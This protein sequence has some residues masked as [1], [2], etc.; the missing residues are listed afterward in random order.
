MCTSRQVFVDC[1][2][3]DP[4]TC[5]HPMPFQ[6]HSSITW[7][8]LCGAE[9][10]WEKPVSCACYGGLPGAGGCPHIQSLAEESS[11]FS[12]YLVPCEGCLILRLK[13]QESWYTVL[14]LLC[15]YYHWHKWNFLYGQELVCLCRYLLCEVLPMQ[16][17]IILYSPGFRN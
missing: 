9:I 10:W 3:L 1:A 7:L 12:V 14:S 17:S 15:L 11:M 13:S 5:K 6:I 4:V 16:P 2:E 8:L